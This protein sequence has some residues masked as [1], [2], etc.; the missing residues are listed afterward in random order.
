MIPRAT[1]IKAA[2][3]FRRGGT[4][5]NSEWNCPAQITEIVVAKPGLEEGLPPFIREDVLQ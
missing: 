3:C 4:P 5:P 1:E 2:S